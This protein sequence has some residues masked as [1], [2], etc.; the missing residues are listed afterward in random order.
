[1]HKNKMRL[2]AW[3]AIACACAAVSL[4]HAA[5]SDGTFTI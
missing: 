5:M 3:V 4:S 2:A 1:M